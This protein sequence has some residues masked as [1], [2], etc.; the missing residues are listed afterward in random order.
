MLNAQFIKNLRL[1]LLVIVVGVGVAITYLCFEYA[2]H[3][4]TS[5]IWSD[6]FQTE[7]YRFLVLPLCLALTLLYFGVRHLLD[8][9]SEK[10]TEH[11]LGDAPSPTGLNF[12]KVLAIGFLSLVA[13]ASLGPEAILVP[14][15]IIIGGYIGANFA[16]NKKPANKLFAV[17][18]FIALF[19]AF[20]NSFLVGLMSLILIKRRFSVRIDIKLI[21]L[22]VLA[23]GGS[24]L[25]LKLLGNSS[26]V[27]TPEYSW[28]LD[29][30]TLLILAVLFIAG[31]LMSY[32]LKFTYIASELVAK[33]VRKK[34]WW[35][36]GGAA[37]LVLSL[38]YL[39]GGP[40]VQ[41]TGNESIVPMVKQSAELGILGLAWLLIIKLLAISWSQTSG[42][43]GGLVFPSVF[44]ASLVV[45]MAKLAAVDFNFIYGLI[46]VMIGMLVLDARNKVLV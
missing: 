16:G 3:H 40:L 13:G 38:L 42:Y 4:S 28:A 46:A 27:K 32:L 2:V 17:A 1:S 21:A 22:A 30:R 14:A 34:Q 25:T 6:L 9:K 12:I 18:G 37:G 44:A 20:F 19:T 43:R 45:A 26:Y 8:P 35:L 15:S 31:C 23:S 5:Y 41:F 39:L 24:A 7:K 10:K 36:K 11:G 33:T 29:V